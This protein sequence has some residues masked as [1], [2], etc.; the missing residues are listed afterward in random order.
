VPIVWDD[1]RLLSGYPGASAT[2]AR[3]AGRRWY[4]GAIDAGAGRAVRLPLDFLHPGRRYVA[5]IVED[6]PGGGLSATTRRVT[7]A[8]VLRLRTGR[9]GGYAVRFKPARKRR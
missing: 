1:T 9:A 4:V 2:I 5:W 3:R 6:A 7:A 8:S